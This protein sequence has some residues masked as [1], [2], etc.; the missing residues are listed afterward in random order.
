LTGL[1]AFVVAVVAGVSV[2]A[3]V[4]DSAGASGSAV[5]AAVVAGSAAGTTVVLSPPAA[6]CA[7]SEVDDKARAAAIAVPA[8][9]S[10]LRVYIMPYQ[11]APARLGR[12]VK[13]EP[14]RYGDELKNA[15]I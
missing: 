2:T 5:V 15:A 8:K 10:V 11:P 13:G 12:T 6:S 9:L 14:K 7:A 3:E 1:D 4:L